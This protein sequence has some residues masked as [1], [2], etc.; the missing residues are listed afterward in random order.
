MIPLAYEIH[1]DTFTKSIQKCPQLTFSR[2]PTKYISVFFNFSLMLLL[3]LVLFIF[4]SAYFFCFCCTFCSF[5][6]AICD[7]FPLQF[8]SFLMKLFYYSYSQINTTIYAQTQRNSFHCSSS[9]AQFF[10]FD[11]CSLAKS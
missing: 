5:H 2:K 7:I 8:L 1:I 9:M 4:Y 6:L 3:K 10:L 11:F